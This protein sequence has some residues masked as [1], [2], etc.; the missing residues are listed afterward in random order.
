M[1]SF[2]GDGGDLRLF[3]NL[4]MLA[5]PQ[6]KHSHL[7]QLLPPLFKK[8]CLFIDSP[9]QIDCYGRVSIEGASQRERE[10]MCCRS[11]STLDPTI[12]L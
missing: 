10:P 9:G 4:S 3:T 11:F 8:K 12:E 1:L 7:D 5:V 6:A 2:F